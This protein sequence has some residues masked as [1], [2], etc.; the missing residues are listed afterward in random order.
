MRRE[1][2]MRG[3]QRKTGAKGGGSRRGRRVPP[4]PLVARTKPS[5]RHP[6]GRPRCQRWKI[7]D[8]DVFWQCTHPAR[9]GFQACGLH[10]S[11][12]AKRERQ[13]TRE[14]PATAA[15]RTGELAKPETLKQLWH[16]KPEIQKIYRAEIDGDGLLDL[17][18]QL[19][20]AK[21]LARYFTETAKLDDT[22]NSF[23]KTPPALAAIDALNRVMDTAERLLKIDER[24][25]PITHQELRAYTR[26]VAT[27]IVRFVPAEQQAAAFAFLR[28]RAL[29]GD[30]NMAEQPAGPDRDGEP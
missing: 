17:R 8:G 2:A 15:V 22:D 24:L 25:G 9:D 21:A 6:N 10:G 14:N 13:G 3:G 1:G 5:R 12:Y 23:G 19:A 26:A 18:P 29:A 4:L 16:D 28:E 30:G 11:G 27:T 7:R 20:M